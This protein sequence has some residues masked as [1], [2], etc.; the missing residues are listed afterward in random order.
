[1]T[2]ASAA[3]AVWPTRRRPNRPTT[4]ELSQDASAIGAAIAGEDEADVAA[5]VEGIEDD[6]L[7]RG[8]V[9]DQRRE[10]DR[11]RQRVAARQRVADRRCAIALRSS[12]A[13]RASG[14]I[15][16]AASPAAASTTR[17]AS[18]ARK[19]AS[20]RKIAR[21]GA[22]SRIAWPMFGREH[23]HQH[24]DHEDQA[25]D[26]RHGLAPRT[27]RGPS[28]RPAR[29]SP[30]PTRPSRRGRRSAAESSRR[31][32]TAGRKSRRG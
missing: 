23:R 30:P 11:H 5:F 25:H 16:D 18:A 20:T 7:D 27:G 8:D 1:M 19:P 31:S 22:N 12:R 4:R 15:P 28:R 14:G 10:A 32:R 3:A 21:H 2:T 13:S 6:L 26:P 17:P 24:E 29:A 9:G